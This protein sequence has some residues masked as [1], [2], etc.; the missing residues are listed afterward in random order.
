MKK[1]YMVIAIFTIITLMSSMV[2]AAT[3]SKFEVVDDQ[4]CTIKINDY[5]SFEKKMTS[6][7]LDKRQVTIQLK[8]TNDA[9]TD[10]PTGEVM[11]LLDNSGSM[12][13]ETST[14]AKRGD[15]VFGSA[16][17]LVQKMLKNNDNLKVGI[18]RFSTN[19]DISKEGTL[20][21][22]SIVS[23]LSN[24]VNALTSAIDSIENNGP[25]T[26]LDSGLNLVKE[27]F[28]NANTNKYI[29]VLTDGVPN[30]AL[31]VANDYYGPEVI[32]KTKATLQSLQADNFK[33]I[34]MLTGINNPEQQ[35]GVH[36]YTF[37]YVI[38][39]IFGTTTNPT[40]GKFYYISDAQ[41]EKTVKE[42]IY[43]DL[44]PTPQSITDI[45]INDFFPKEIV[46]NFE[47]AY[48]SQPTKGTISKAIDGENKIVWSIDELSSGETATVQYTLTLK[49]NYDP[50]IVNVILD[51]NEKV[52]ITY[53]DF[54]GKDGSK[55]SDETPKVRI[56]EPTTPT[57][58]PSDPTTAKTILPKAGSTVMIAGIGIIALVAIASG[59]RIIKINKDMKK[60]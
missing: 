35:A 5:C 12:Q 28:S 42:D 33:V 3:T 40:A 41:I 43:S 31:G 36:D 14:G 58:T 53:K 17:T 21:D 37:Q 56:T 15:I 13:D 39:N 1:T 29:I 26:D 6:Y 2:F 16:K 55:T 57:P 34:T 38:D 22:A 27:H 48:V 54:D 7:D 52:T 8:I 25:R 30:V 4:V 60:Q 44:L 19:T 20:E 9:P 24:D 46:D 23:E 11:L 10:K 51:T 50:S 47:F 59:A 32:S 45:K 18:A 49:D